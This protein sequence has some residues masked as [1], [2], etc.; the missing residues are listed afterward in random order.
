M[1]ASTEGTERRRPAGQSAG[2]ASPANHEI[3]ETISVELL[4]KL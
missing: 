2:A 1:I 4:N 3:K